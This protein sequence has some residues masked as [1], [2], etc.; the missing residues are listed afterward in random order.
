MTLVEMC[1]DV[2]KKTG[3]DTAVIE[4]M[5]GQQWATLKSFSRTQ[6]DL[7]VYLIDLNR[8][9]NKENG[10]LFKSA[11]CR[12]KTHYNCFSLKCV[13]TCHRR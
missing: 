1:T 3:L 4:E 12:N 8:A 5:A 2:S 11:S 13:C 9:R 7:L 10:E 6:S